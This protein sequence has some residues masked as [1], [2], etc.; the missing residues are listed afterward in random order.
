MVSTYNS[1]TAIE[2]I[3]EIVDEL[4]KTGTMEN[5]STYEIFTLAIKIQKNIIKSEYNQLYASAN[6]VNTGEL[7]PSA[8]E[9][10]A[11]E[12]ERFNNNN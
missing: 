8:L 12:I 4:E 10:I 3:N 5:V 11:M 2:Q 7:V 9:K 1:L 6:V